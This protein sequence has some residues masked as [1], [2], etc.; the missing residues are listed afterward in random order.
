MRIHCLEDLYG[1]YS[2]CSSP[3]PLPAIA[4][5]TAPSRDQRVMNSV[6]SRLDEGDLELERVSELEVC[7]PAPAGR[8]KCVSLQVLMIRT[9]YP[10]KL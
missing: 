3:P 7:L 8:I 6:L 5:L 9:T 4:G 2:S 1:E 10:A